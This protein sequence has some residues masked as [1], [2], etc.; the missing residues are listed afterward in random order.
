MMRNRK[1]RAEEFGPKG[2]VQLTKLSV[3]IYLLYRVQI[4]NA[5]EICIL[6]ARSCCCRVD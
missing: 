6:P 1:G 3:N 2:I 4:H 5:L